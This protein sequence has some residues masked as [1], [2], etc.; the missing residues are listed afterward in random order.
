MKAAGCDK[1]VI[2][3]AGAGTRVRRIS[4][5]RPK[6]LIELAGRPIIEW[7]LESL[8]RGGISKVVM[9]TGFGAPALRKA[10]GTGRR[11]GL[12]IAYVHNPGWKKPNGMS[13]YAARTAISAGER[14]LVLM[15]D[16]LLPPRLIAKTRKARTPNCVLAVDTDI[17][18]VFDL[19]DATKVRLKDGKPVA[20]GKKLR[21]YDAA[22]C[23]LFRLD[24]R[25]F[26]ALARS[27]TQGVLS[28]SGGIKILIEQGDLDV[29]PVADMFWI[30]ID[31]PKAHRQASEHIDVF[32]SELKRKPRPRPKREQKPKPRPKQKPKP[33]RK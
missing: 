19:S 21:T 8:A 4:E 22:D 3:A 5:Q 15:S 28:L 16:H 1:A 31:T 26:P 11:Y 32:I 25:V 13:L 29:L 9:V 30:D 20:I 2:L 17:D 12:K 14:F 6:C 24:G 27:F 10:L 18:R 7:I 33:K 23:G